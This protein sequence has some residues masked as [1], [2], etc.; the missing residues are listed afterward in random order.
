VDDEGRLRKA[1][2]RSLCREHRRILVAASGP[3][4]LG[5]L[6]RHKVDVLITELV[7]PGMDGMA[8]I[9][10]V[11]DTCDAIRTIIITAYGSSESMAE[12]ETLGV[13]HYLAKPFDLSE[14]K[15]RV[16]ELL[17]SG[18]PCPSSWVGSVG[19][20]ALQWAC[21]AAGRGLGTVVSLSRIGRRCAKAM[22]AGGRAA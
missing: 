12:A 19:C 17:A 16:D 18:G 10:R 3:E 8:L 4:A 15:S 1:L 2:G 6:A 5:L 22:V 14:L 21:C 7:I 13:S 11:R 20:G 9:R